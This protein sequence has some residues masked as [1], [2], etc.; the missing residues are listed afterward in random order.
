MCGIVGVVLKTK[1]GLTKPIE[2]TF[3]QMLFADTLRGDDSTGIISVERDTTFH[4]TKEACPAYWFLPMYHASQVSKDMWSRGKAMI[5]HNRKKTIG[6]VSDETAH[7]FVVNDDF[8]MVHNGTL[9]NHKSLADTTVDSEALAIVLAEA[10][11][12]EDYKEKLEETLGRVNGAYAVA[13][14]DQRHNRVRL[15]RNRERPLALIETST[16]YYFASEAGMLAWVLSRNNI[17]IKDLKLE[18]VPEHTVID[19]NLDD[20]TVTRVQVEPKKVKPP[21]TTHTA[22]GGAT[23]IMGGIKFTKKTKPKEDGLSKNKF[24][25]FRNRYLNKKIQWWSEDFIEKNFP[26]TEIDGETSFVLMG[27]CDELGEDHMIRAEVDIKELQI[28]KGDDLVNRLWTGTVIDMAYEKRARKMILVV[29]N[30][31]PTPVSYRKQQQLPQIVDAEYIRNKLDEQE[32]AF[33]ALH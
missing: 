18:I 6:A 24:K 17:S 23:S 19:F 20:D 7:P 13:M 3:N 32:K 25:R 21:V 31:I 16:A 5:G 26:K 10:F 14:Y 28:A 8:A 15:L 9:Y 27:V 33:T 2:D 4:I 11:K 29:D 1:F 22:A 12:E 30:A